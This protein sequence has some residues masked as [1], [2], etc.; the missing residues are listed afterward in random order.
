MPSL[1]RA[2]AKTVAAGVA[3]TGIAFGGTL[4]ADN[5]FFHSPVA[6]M[7]REYKS[8]FVGKYD[9]PNHPGCLR[10][11][12]VCTHLLATTFSPHLLT[13]SAYLM[14]FYVHTGQGERSY[15]YW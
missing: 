11:I 5:V 15:H 1:P 3:S 6:A 14:K 10:K 13:P 8:P 2:F 4:M 7:A 9:D 12:E